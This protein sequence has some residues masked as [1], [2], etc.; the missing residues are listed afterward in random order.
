LA[1]LF[2]TLPE[3]CGLPSYARFRFAVRA[4]VEAAKTRRP[5]TLRDAICCRERLDV[6]FAFSCWISFGAALVAWTRRS[7]ST[8]GGSSL[9]RF[10]FNHRPIPYG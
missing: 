9:I 1:L 10:V 6:V 7:S 3:I 2:L 8:G 4:F 5:R